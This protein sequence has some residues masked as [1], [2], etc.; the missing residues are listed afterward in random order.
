[1]I[2]KLKSPGTPDGSI[3]EYRNPIRGMEWGESEFISV[4]FELEIYSIVDNVHMIIGLLN[5]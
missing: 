1:M 2:R 5:Y 3:L 4:E